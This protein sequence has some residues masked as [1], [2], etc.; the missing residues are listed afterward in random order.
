[1]SVYPRLYLPFL[2]SALLFAPCRAVPLTD[3]D[4]IVLANFDNKTGETV[5]DD[6]LTQALLIALEQSPFLK[7]LSDREVSEALRT[8][9]RAATERITPDVGRELC[10]RTGSIKW[11]NLQPA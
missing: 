11:N 4:T 3:K 10:L 8:M 1:M 7:M 9:G 6:A 2:L 5:F